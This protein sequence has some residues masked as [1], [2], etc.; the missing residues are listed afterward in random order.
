VA[1]WRSSSRG[2]CGGGRREPALVAAGVARTGSGRA[3]GW[4]GGGRSWV[5]VGDG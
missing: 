4:C 5:A 1:G 2:A 3:E